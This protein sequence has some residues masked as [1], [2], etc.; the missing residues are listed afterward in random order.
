MENW[1]TAGK[2]LR[3]LR[4]ETGLSIYKVARAI[5]VS[6]NYISL[7]ERGQ[8][9]PS[10]AVLISLCD[11]YKVERAVLFD[12]YN[13]VETTKLDQILADPSL[14]KILNQMS[15]D[16]KLSSEDLASIET[17]LQVIKYRLDNNKE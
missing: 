8:Q 9:Q 2:K 1:K 5:G 11:F 3:E 12:L 17:E 15:T 16:K 14:R 7:L 6:G 13:R 10:D 4:K